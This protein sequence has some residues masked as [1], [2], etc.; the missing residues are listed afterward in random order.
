MASG[1]FLKGLGIEKTVQI[2]L[3][4]VG[5]VLQQFGTKIVQQ[6][7][8]SLTDKSKYDTLLGQSITFTSK[9]FGH[10]YILALD[11]DDYW[12]WVDK[13]RKPTKKKAAG[14]PTLK[15]KL[16]GIDGW[17]A[18]KPIKLPTEYSYKRTLKDGTEKTGTYKYKNNKFGTV[19][20]KSANALAFLISRK[21]HTKGYKGNN[22][23]SDVVTDSLLADLKKDL[24]K[25]VHKDITL[26]II[27]G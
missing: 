9:I 24:Q 6:L 4:G 5:G 21:I 16:L 15:Q 7:R 19:R 23:Y 11:M 26:S 18:R 8:K 10:V 25:A 12:Y 14:S 22:F 1:D 17:I 2:K 3:E 20:E 13:G 27:Q